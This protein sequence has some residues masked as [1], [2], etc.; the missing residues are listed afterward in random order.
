MLL[1]FTAREKLLHLMPKGGVVA[2]IG[3][4]RGDFSQAIFDVVQ[5]DQLH[6]IDPWVHQEGESYRPDES[7]VSDAEHGKNL[8]AVKARFADEIAAGRVVI[9]R[10]FSTDAAPD[11]ADHTFDWV[12][13]DG[14]HTYDA[15]LSDLRAFEGKIKPG[16]M[17]L[18]HDYANYP[19]TE[20]LNYGVIEA[21]DAFVDD[22]GFEI[23]LVTVEGHATFVLRDTTETSRSDDLLGRVIYNV[24]AVVELKQFTGKQLVQR[25]VEYPDQARRILFS[26]K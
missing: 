6:L 21:V 7:N 16:G 14:D 26:I 3:T 4:F 8:D 5:P 25:V 22:S 19:G 11:F 10:K 18:G 2:E 15:V 12:Y 9:H 1:V 23:L 17:I 20:K 13:V 24:P